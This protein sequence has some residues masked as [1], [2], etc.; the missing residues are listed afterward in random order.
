MRIK[1]LVLGTSNPGKIKEWKKLI[2]NSFSLIAA[3]DFNV[4][5][6]KEKGYSFKEIAKNKAIYYTKLTKEFVLSEDGGF[7][8]DYLDGAPGIKSRRILPG[9]REGSD[10]EL[11]NFIIS[12]LKGV[13]TK[14]RKAR[15]IV[16]VVLADPKG[17]IIFE[18]KGSIEGFVSDKAK[19]IMESGYPYR[20]ILF[21]PE[22]KK[23]YS[24]FTEKDH[25]KFDHRRPI[26]ER[27]IKFLIEY[28]QNG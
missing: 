28:E 9:D 23:M 22:V 10:E 11:V 8:V 17:N 20:S 27:L 19:G 1:H 4:K 24:E 18:D 7:E 14:K 25:E 13:P 12:K 21:I 6:P 3:L 15:L 5:S 26:A 2:G 16:N